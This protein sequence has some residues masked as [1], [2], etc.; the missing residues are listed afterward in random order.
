M[1][2]LAGGLAEAGD[3]F[4]EKVIQSF[5]KYAWTKFANPVRPHVIHFGVNSLVV[6]SDILLMCRSN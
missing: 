2:V 6:M 5:N 3:V 1:I 4:I